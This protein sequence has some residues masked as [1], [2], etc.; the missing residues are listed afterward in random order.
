MKPVQS[1]AAVATATRPLPGP[2]APK[3]EVATSAVGLTNELRPAAGRDRGGVAQGPGPDRAQ[4][5]AAAPAERA[6]PRV[7]EPTLTAL[8]DEITTLARTHHLTFYFLG[9]KLVLE[10]LFSG[11]VASWQQRGPKHVALTRLVVKLDERGIDRTTLGRAVGT[12]LMLSRQGGFEDLKR[13]T[14]THVRLLLPLSKARQ[15][16]LVARVESEG[17]SVTQL[18]EVIAALPEAPEK[19]P[20]LAARLLRHTR[21]LASDQ[22]IFT[23]VEDAPELTDE[24]LEEVFE[25]LTVTTQRCQAL[26]ARVT[27]QRARRRPWEA[28]SGSG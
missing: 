28:R 27:E 7:D 17:L 24:V 18:K 11:S 14:F 26:L 3:P 10:R 4:T 6:A 5:P 19:R 25:K 16:E 13:L 21:A 12:Y 1:G 23:E 15:D 20:K 2:R 22:S 8:A 9:G